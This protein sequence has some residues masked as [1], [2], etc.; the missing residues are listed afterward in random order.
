MA[1]RD[2]VVGWRWYLW[3]MPPRYMYGFTNSDTGMTGFD[4]FRFMVRRV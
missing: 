3:L 4:P 1:F 2:N